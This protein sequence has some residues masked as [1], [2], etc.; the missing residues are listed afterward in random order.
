MSNQTAFPLKIATDRE[1]ISLNPGEQKMVN[2][3]F[4]FT[5]TAE[6]GGV[7]RQFSSRDHT[8]TLDPASFGL[9]QMPP[10]N[11]PT[12]TERMAPEKG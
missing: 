3:G 12:N 2:R 10:E 11:Y 4:D 8:I 1:V 5:F 9:Q 6:G 7:S